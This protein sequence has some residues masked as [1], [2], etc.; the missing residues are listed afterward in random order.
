MMT[1]HNEIHTWA[2]A[3]ACLCWTECGLKFSFGTNL[4]SSV[5]MLILYANSTGGKSGIYIWLQNGTYWPT[6]SQFTGNK[7]ICKNHLHLHI[8]DIVFW[9]F[10]RWDTKY[11]RLWVLIVSKFLQFA[12][13]VLVMLNMY[14]YN[15]ENLTFF[16]FGWK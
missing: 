14:N 7:F 6:Q 2:R 10:Y 12:E 3:R 8:E 11:W 5:K 15:V 16:R 4:T 13:F 1:F 9:I